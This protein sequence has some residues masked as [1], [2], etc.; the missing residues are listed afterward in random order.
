MQ[1]VAGRWTEVGRLLTQY[2]TVRALR[3]N[4][5]QIG[6]LCLDSERS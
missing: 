3:K 1:E 4:T 6:L 2:N 5:V